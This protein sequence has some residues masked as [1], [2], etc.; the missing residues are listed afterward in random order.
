MSND[1]PDPILFL[2]DHRGTNI[3]RDFA[4]GIK[5]EH[6]IGFGIGEDWNV[7]ADPNN[8]SYWVAWD[9]C[10]RDAIVVDPSLADDPIAAAHA[11]MVARDAYLASD[12][13]WHA[14]V[15]AIPSVCRYSVQQDGACWLVPVDM[16]SDEK[17]REWFYPG[18]IAI[19]LENQ[20]DRDG[21]VMVDAVD[22][23]QARH[24][25]C[26][27]GSSWEIV[28][29]D[30]A[31]TMLIDRPTL[32]AELEAA[33]YIVDQSEYSAPTAEDMIAL[34]ARIDAENNS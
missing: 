29:G 27:D 18:P 30:F 31:Y 17:T 22:H 24:D 32:V 15:E 20:T 33:G 14:L 13:R 3:P 11:L 26:I 10:L 12:K 34:R 9:E 19:R 16:V 25:G 5:H 1:R 28:D 4:E 6:V 8:E 7:L 23:R 21:F 2:D